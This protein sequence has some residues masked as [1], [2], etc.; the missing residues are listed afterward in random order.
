MCQMRAT[1]LMILPHDFSRFL[2]EA[3]SVQPRLAMALARRD[4]RLRVEVRSR[5]KR[6]EETEPPTSKRRGRRSDP[7]IEPLTTSVCGAG[8]L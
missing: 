7:L 6:V 3:G 2:H 5:R 1:A 4:D 8:H